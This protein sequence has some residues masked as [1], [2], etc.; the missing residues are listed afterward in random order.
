MKKRVWL[1]LLENNEDL[2]RLLADELRRYGLDAQGHVWEDDL[3]QFAWAGAIPD[4]TRADCA[5]WIIAGAATRFDDPVTRKGLALLA[6]AAQVAH[7]P[8]FP[9][10]LSPSAAKVDPLSLPT[11]L[12]SAE[13]V[14]SGLGAKAA[15]RANAKAA[16]PVADYRLAVHPMPGLGLWFE[17]GPAR[18]P[19]QGAILGCQGG[20]D[21]R[22]DAQGVGLAGSVPNRSTLKYPVRDMRIQMQDREYLTWGAKNAISPAESLFVRVTETPDNLIFGAFPEDDAAEV[23]SVTLV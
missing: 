15:V 13:C 16:S 9:I 7:G 22:P 19:W 20:K 21:A 10:L 3:A 23:F 14:Q 8:D 2:G 5:L 17:V 6:L 1:S 18:D 12:R 11:P 4:L